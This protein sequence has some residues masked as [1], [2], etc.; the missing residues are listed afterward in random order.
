MPSY[1]SIICKRDVDGFLYLSFTNG[2]LVKGHN[3]PEV[4]SGLCGRPSIPISL[5]PHND[6]HLH[7]AVSCP[8]TNNEIR[9]QLLPLPTEGRGWSLVFIGNRDQPPPPFGRYTNY[10]PNEGCPERI[11]A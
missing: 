5:R 6:L 11:S 2:L 7:W 9:C 8:F 1:D 3:S 4:R 10:F